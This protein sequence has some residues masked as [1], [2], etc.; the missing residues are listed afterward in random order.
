MIQ[1]F[2]LILTLDLSDSVLLVWGKSKVH[3]GSLLCFHSWLQGQLNAGLV[4]VS[5]CDQLP[6][7]PT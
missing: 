1:M 5:A 7:L 4:C 3:F 2:A 6:A